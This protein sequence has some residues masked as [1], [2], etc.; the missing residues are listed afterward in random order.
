MSAPHIHDTVAA[1]HFPPYRVF[2]LAGGVKVFAVQDQT[3][4]LISLSVIAKAGSTQESCEGEAAFA[5]AMLSR[6][7]LRRSTTQFAEDVDALGAAL[8]SM[9]HRDTTGVAATGL[10]QHASTLVELL[11][12]CVL[13]PAFDSEE[14]ERLRFQSV[15]DHEY[16]LSDPQ[17]LA[18][19]AF[20]KTM[21]GEHPYAS[22]RSG[23]LQSLSEMSAAQ[24]SQFYSDLRSNAPWFI[25]VAGNFENEQIDKDLHK[26]FD[27]LTSRNTQTPIIPV[28]PI[29][30]TRCGFAAY[31]NARQVVLS[32]GQLTVGRN[33]KAYPAI[34]LLTTMFGGYFL[35]RLNSIIRE[36]KGFSYGVH[37]SLDSMVH[38]SK[39]AAS[40]S[41]SPENLAETIDILRQQW[42]RL[43]S[44]KISEAELR[45][46]KRF[47]LGSFAR[48][49]ETPQQVAQ[50]LG[51]AEEAGLEPQY[52]EEFVQRIASLSVDELFAVQQEFI[53]PESL[54]IAA[55]GKKTDVQ[56]VLEQVAETQELFIE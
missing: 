51:T 37:A 56:P 26:H 12:E 35:S 38:A 49:M 2:Q 55:A 11:A 20:S 36:E 44:E 23:T 52:Y 16:S 10:T 3:Q 34:Q 30:S 7:S 25:V 39:M 21:F 4:E 32:V 24:C 28:K 1:F 14:F 19:R 27:S 17:F 50:F 5:A 54:V 45:Q 6:G 53:L 33:N 13:E 15:S 48:S 46:C 29:H 43:A 9:G 8:R 18:H 41:I 40:C 31:E 42:K 47:I 22:S